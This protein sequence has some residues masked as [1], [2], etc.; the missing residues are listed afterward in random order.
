MVTKD[1]D[2]GCGC[3]AVVMTNAARGRDWSL[4]QKKGVIG[5]TGKCEE[6]MY[7]GRCYSIT[8][9]FLILI[10]VLWLCKMLILEN[11]GEE[12]MK[13]LCTIFAP[14]YQSEIISNMQSLKSEKWLL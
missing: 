7:I 3:W 13:V 4:G 11:L 5:T 8:V 9:N 2:W 10:I 6:D 12:Y 14:F 1:K